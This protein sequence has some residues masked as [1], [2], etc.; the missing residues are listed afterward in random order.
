MSLILKNLEAENQH[1]LLK[2]CQR[3]DNYLRDIGLTVGITGGSLMDEISSVGHGAILSTATGALFGRKGKGS[4]GGGGSGSGIGILG[5]AGLTNTARGGAVGAFIGAIQDARTAHKLGKDPTSEYVNKDFGE[6]FAMASTIRRG[7]GSA[8][9]AGATNSSKQRA[10]D[11]VETMMNGGTP[12]N[13]FAAR[14]GGNAVGFNELVSSGKYTSSFNPNGV[15][16]DSLKDVRVG[17]GGA[18]GIDKNTG[19]LVAFTTEKPA[20]ESSTLTQFQGENGVAYYAQDLTI[21]NQE[22]QAETGVNYG[23]YVD[24]LNAYQGEGPVDFRESSY[25][26]SKYTEPTK[27]YQAPEKPYQ[28][29]EKPYRKRGKSHHG[30]PGDSSPAYQKG[31]NPNSNN[32]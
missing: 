14:I 13:A 29:P 15:K 21:A 9:L 18:V 28:G 32:S 8:F 19:H 1:T 11:T 5:K 4:G 16:L 27:S 31:S 20:F 3:F 17:A 24:T 30:N 6:R 7:A 23:G 10:A 22:Y 12:I 26:T 25:K 2:I